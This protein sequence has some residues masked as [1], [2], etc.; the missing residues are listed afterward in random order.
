MFKYVKFVDLPVSD[1]DRAL[2]F[3]TE[4]LRLVVAN[5]SPYEENWRWIEVEIPG[6]QT[7]LLFT[8]RPDHK[9]DNTPALILIT[10][11][12]D[13]THAN[14]KGNDVSF[15]Q[16]PA[17]APWMPGQRYALFRDSENNTIMMGTG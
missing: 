3:Y 16:E 12:I 9:P 1:Q 17:E 11:N 2:K 13:E 7:R 10:E 4:K 5:D 6:A 8:K 14:L 15:I